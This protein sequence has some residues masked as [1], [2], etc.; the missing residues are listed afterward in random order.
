[1]S[2]G[3]GEW[4]KTPWGTGTELPPPGIIA[5]SPTLSDELGGTIITVVGTNFSSPATIEIY[6]AGNVLAGVCITHDDEFD[7]ART[8][9][10]CG[11]PALPPGTYGVQ[12]VTDGGSSGIFENAFTAEPFADQMKIQ[13]SRR[14]WA[15][16]WAVGRRILSV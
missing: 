9:I 10:R 1:M 5:V 6:T 15:R 2:W 8:V 3:L 4:G 14:S 11:T 13:R 7:I 12:V 16:L